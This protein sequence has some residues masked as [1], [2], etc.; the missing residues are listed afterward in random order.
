MSPAGRFCSQCQTGQPPFAMISHN[1]SMMYSRV[2]RIGMVSRTSYFA[3]LTAEGTIIV[4]GIL[5]SCYADIAAEQNEVHALF[6]PLRLL[7]QMKP[8]W[9]AGDQSEVHTLVS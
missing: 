6:A 4:D 7:H 1:Q 9:A 8:Q 5:A 3:P 2:S